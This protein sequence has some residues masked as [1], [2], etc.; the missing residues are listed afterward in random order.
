[1]KGNK[2]AALFVAIA[3]FAVFSLTAS[4]AA[5]PSIEASQ[6]SLTDQVNVSITNAKPN[7]PISVRIKNADDEIDFYEMGYVD[8]D[9]NFEFSYINDRHS[10]D[11]YIEAQIGSIRVN[12]SYFKMD[13]AMYDEFI[14]AINAQ[15]ALQGTG[16]PDGAPIK[17]VFDR[18]E[19]KF[20]LDTGVYDELSSSQQEN[21]Y[22]LMA[23]DPSFV[24]EI[25]GF[26]D[27]LDAFY[28]AVLLEKCNEDISS[29]KTLSQTMPYKEAIGADD[30]APVLVKS[31]NEISNTLL[32]K[33]Y[34]EMP[35][36]SDNVKKMLGDMEFKIFNKAIVNA[37][38][39]NDV[40]TMYTLY[41]S[42]T[43]VNP[44]KATMTHFK[45]L[46]GADYDTY[47]EYGTALRKKISAGQQNNPG[48]NNSS[49]G[50]GGGSGGGGGNFVV[51]EPSAGNTKPGD[52]TSS[53]VD[54][55]SNKLVFSDMTEA[56]WA[57]KAV[58]HVYEK[59]IIAGVGDGKFEPN[60]VITRAE[61]V[62]IIMAMTG[63]TETTE[64]P[65]DDVKETDW[66]YPY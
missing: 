64:L 6:V 45:S 2:L 42:Y 24:G 25:E 22:D 33:V 52:D 26:G 32:A 57:V 20:Q 59:G 54:T 48:G 46:I 28:A 14:D 40:K 47:T 65:F 11:M 61:V 7:A 18:Y 41:E 51:S 15:H 60:R 37:G 36:T 30:V 62:K 19:G 5:M 49:G 38:S 13:D 16:N 43:G 27:V 58:N 53:S 3:S 12:G 10:G 50:N 17:E 29:I 9:G 56:L 1:M 44:E 35:E 63:D 4:A 31:I 23:N 39:W 8:A 55:D 66:F 21:V 34:S